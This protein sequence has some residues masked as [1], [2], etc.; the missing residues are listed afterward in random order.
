MKDAL[1]RAG[2]DPVLLFFAI[3][4]F[5]PNYLGHPDNYIEATRFRRAAHI[6]PEWY[7]FRSTRSCVLYRPKSWVGQIASFVTVILTPSSLWCL[8][9]FGAIAV[10]GVGCLGWTHPRCVRGR[11]RPIVQMAGLRCW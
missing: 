7:F 6:V 9:M 5:M 1:F 8:A 4:D 10:D 11:Y 3:G 2:R